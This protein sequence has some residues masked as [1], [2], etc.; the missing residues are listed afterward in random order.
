LPGSQVPTGQCS[1]TTAISELPILYGGE[2]WELTK[3]PFAVGTVRSLVHAK[4]AV[5]TDDFR[6][7]MF[8]ETNKASQFFF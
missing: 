5:Y 6:L 7:G 8:S 4:Q 3:Q 2:H 1:F